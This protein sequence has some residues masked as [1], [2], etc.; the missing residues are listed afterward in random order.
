MELFVVNLKGSIVVQADSQEAA[1]DKV[2]EW[3]A[4]VADKTPN[5]LMPEVTAVTLR[6][7]KDRSAK[8]P[9]EMLLAE[10]N[11]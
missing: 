4:L 9:R 5:L 10:T 1:R 8:K 11:R 3:A 2:E 6:C 7:E